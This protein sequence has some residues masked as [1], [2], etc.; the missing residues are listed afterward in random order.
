MS[1]LALATL[2]FGT[3][4][5]AYA[6][7]EDSK[8]GGFTLVAFDVTLDKIEDVEA[9]Q[10]AAKMVLSSTEDDLLFVGEYSDRTEKPMR[11]NSTDEALLAVDEITDKLKSNVGGESASANLS[12]MLESYALF[13]EQ[14]GNESGGHLLVLSAGDFTYDQSVDLEDLSDVSADLASDGVTVSTVSLATTPGSDREVL[15]A[16]SDAAGGRAFD[17][18][19]LDGVIEFIDDQLKI[20]LHE[21]LQVEEAKFEG[22]TVRVDVPPHSSYLVAVFAFE[23]GNAVNVIEQPNGQEIGDSVGSVSAIS[24][25][26]MKLFTVRNPQPGIWYLKSFGGSG[27]VRMYNDVIN[28]IR[29][30][31]PATLPFQTGEPIVLMADARLGDLPLIDSSATIKAV[32]TQ[33]NGSKRDYQLNDRGVDG[34]TYPEDGTFSATVPA[35]SLVGLNEVELSLTWPDISASIDAAGG[36]VVETFP[37]I[38]I[39]L[40]ELDA[41]VA[42]GV[43]T[44]L[45]TVDLKLGD[46]PFLAKQDEIIVSM[47]S[48][49]DGTDVAL[50]FEP[51][52]I[53]DDKLYQLRVFGSVVMSAEY[54]FNAILRSTYL[55]REFEAMALERSMSINVSTTISLP[56]LIGASTVGVIGIIAVSMLLVALIRTKPYGYL[57]RLDSHGE[58]ELVAD[59]G[60]YR[61]SVWDWFI[62]KS[63]VPAAALPGVPLLGGRFMFSKWGLIF[64]YEPDKDGIL[65][66]TIRGEGLQIGRNTIP[67]NERFSIGSETFVFDRSAL[68]DA[69]RVSDRLRSSQLARNSELDNFAL[70]PMTWDAPSGARPT[71]RMY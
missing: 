26:G 6:G 16:I 32:V 42:E 46:D 50:E 36:F 44:H 22:R 63:I 19:F 23:D 54:V 52:E 49:E 11:F 59:F 61:C 15:A 5:L 38:E 66:M 13:V 34:D 33:P 67:D 25:S 58:R 2:I 31:T 56:L 3:N 29:V 51:T 1:L 28:D 41:P 14:L 65:R 53:V 62:H 9:A 55:E 69:V 17:L 8:S 20:A 39:S 27:S 24:I 12:Q 10:L 37:I 60:A 57:Y 21:S 30:H 68:D 43:R 40:V 47:V 18:G 64:Y 45:A 71:R 70:D 4:R 48:A 35:Q 7:I